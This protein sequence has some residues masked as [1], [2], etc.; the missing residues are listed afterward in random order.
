VPK[1]LL[2]LREGYT[3]LDKQLGDLEAAR[4]EA[5]SLDEFWRITARDFCRLR[6]CGHA[7]PAHVPLEEHPRIMRDVLAS[8]A[9]RYSELDRSDLVEEIASA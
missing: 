9:D 2:E 3:I 5:R 4:R 7:L 6:R 8:G 1:P